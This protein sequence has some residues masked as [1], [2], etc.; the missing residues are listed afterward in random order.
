MN[1]E[2]VTAE[3]RTALQASGTPSDKYLAEAEYFF[4]QWAERLRRHDET[5]LALDA[6]RL[7]LN[8]MTSRLE[9]TL[10][11]NTQLATQ[12]SESQAREARALEDIGVLKGIMHSHGA[13]IADVVSRIGE[14]A[15]PTR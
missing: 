13:S 6:A 8:A 3:R 14:A 12:L 4:H 10:R 15:P 1:D 5:K 7:D 11:S 2:T 9:E